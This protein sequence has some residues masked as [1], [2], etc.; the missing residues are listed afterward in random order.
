ML[1]A[2]ALDLRPVLNLI[3]GD[4]LGVTGHIVRGEG[5]RTFGSDGRHEFVVLV[6]DEVLGSQLTDGVNLM[7]GLLTGLRIRQL[8][9]GLI[10]LFNL[11]QQRSLGLRIIRSELGG[12]LEH[13]VLQIMSQT[14]RL[15]RVVLRTGPHGDIRLNPRSFLIH[16]QIHL[17]SVIQRI[18]PRLHQIPRHR[19]IV[20]C[21]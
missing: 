9:I 17:Q 3:A 11:S 19:D 13:Q 12:T 15:C 6:G 20:T 14:C 5:I 21:W 10:A 8:T 4:V 2:V 1:E 7:I 16:R 18:D